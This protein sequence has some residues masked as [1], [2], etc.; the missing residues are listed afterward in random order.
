MGFFGWV[1]SVLVGKSGKVL[2]VS[3]Y[4]QARVTEKDLLTCHQNNL[5]TTETLDDNKNYYSSFYLSI[6]D[7]VTISIPDT[8][9]LIVE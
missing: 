8:S 6:D 1:Q 7:G 4:E 3:E 2:E 9:N 5:T